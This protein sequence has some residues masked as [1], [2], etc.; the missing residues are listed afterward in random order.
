[1]PLNMSIEV[2]STTE[3]P[4]DIAQ[5]LAEA[6]VALAKL[7]ANRQVI[8]DFDSTG[9][10]GPAKVDDKP[11]TEAYKS[12]WNARR[13]CRQAKAWAASQT[14]LRE[15][16]TETTLVFGRRGNVKENPSRV[17]FRIYVPRPGKDAESET[18][19]SE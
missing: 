14:V 19:N 9:Y 1:M 12:A 11:V 2:S 5:D 3:V 18:D 7:P 16:G 15:D 6:Y 8:V 13:F 10:A 4:E 17:A